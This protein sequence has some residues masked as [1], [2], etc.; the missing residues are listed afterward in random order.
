M[1]T[2]REV[3]QPQLR[4][5]SWGETAP[6]GLG[7]PICKGEVGWDCCLSLQLGWGQVVPGLQ[8][9]ADLNL[10]IFSES[11]P[12]KGHMCGVNLH[13]TDA[14]IPHTFLTDVDA[15][16]AFGLLAVPGT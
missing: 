15:G 8:N 13:D 11:P 7:F 9:E 4:R 12:G 1:H 14:S 2:G 5:R 10:D 16:K 3:T 6:R